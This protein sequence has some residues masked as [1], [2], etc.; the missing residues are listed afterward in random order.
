MESILDALYTSAG[1]L[2]KSLWTLIFGYLI[3]GAIQV[4]IT[5]EQMAKALHQLRPGGRAGRSPRPHG[6]P[7]CF[8]TEQLELGSG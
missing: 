5:R 1:M 3:S 4:L 6:R 7:R 8:A 2:W